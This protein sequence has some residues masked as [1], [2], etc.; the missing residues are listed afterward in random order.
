MQAKG[1]IGDADLQDLVMSPIYADLK[2][3]PLH[4]GKSDFLLSGN[5]IFHRALCRAN[6]LTE[7]VMFDGLPHVHWSTFTMSGVHLSELPGPKR[8]SDCDAELPNGRLSPT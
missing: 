5:S 2:S 6:V 4:D 7:L 3:F 8:T 1:Y